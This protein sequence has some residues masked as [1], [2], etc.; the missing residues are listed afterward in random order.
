MTNTNVSAR[1]RNTILWGGAL[2]LIGVFLL[3]VNQH[4]LDPYAPTWQYVVAALCGLGGI[5]FLILFVR[6]V[7]HW[8]PII[9]AFTLLTVGVIIFLTTQTAA[10][11]GEVL[12][13]ILFFGIALAFAVIFLLDRNRWWAIIP[14]GVLLLVSATTALSTFQVSSDVLSATLFIGMGFVFLLVYLLGPHKREV[15]WALVPA[16]ALVAFGLFTFVFSKA[17]GD[18]QLTVVSWW[19]ALLVLLGVF[20]LVRG[21]A[22]LGGRTL[23]AADLTLPPLPAPGELPAAPSTAVIHPQDNTATS[24]TPSVSPSPPAAPPLLEPEPAA[25]ADAEIPS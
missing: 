2:L 14:M 16:T 13:S 8:W 23:P 1:K 20:L 11:V 5:A 19:P 15:W 4:A 12:G 10:V 6:D 9:P 25:P 17:T 21:V 18:L 24:V 22:M 7:V 3:L